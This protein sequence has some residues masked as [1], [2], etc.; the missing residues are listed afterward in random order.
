MQ[1]L[2]FAAAV[3]IAACGGSSAQGRG[4]NAAVTQ[5][6]DGD[7]ATDPGAGSNAECHDETPTGSSIPRRVCRTKAQSDMDRTGAQDWSGRTRATPTSG[8]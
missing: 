2:I 1:R 8:R 5:G 6:A 4:T 7:A 3:T